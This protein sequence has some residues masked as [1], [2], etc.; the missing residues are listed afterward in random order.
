MKAL[1]LDA[2]GLWSFPIYAIPL[3]LV[4]MAGMGLMMW[5]MMRMMMGMGNHGSSRDSSTSSQGDMSHQDARDREVSDLRAEVAR[6]REELAAS[7]K[8][9][10]NEP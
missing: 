1:F 9:S 6:L 10:A 5:L 3:M 8:K 7:S 4:M 2:G